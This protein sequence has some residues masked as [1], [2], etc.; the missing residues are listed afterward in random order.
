LAIA[1][2]SAPRALGQSEAPTVTVTPSFVSQYMWRGQRLGGLSLQTS[3]EADDRG[4]GLGVWAN[5]P[6]ADKV[7]NQS[8]PEVDPY[9][10]WRLPVADRV[11]VIPGFQIYTYPGADAEKV[12]AGYFRTRCELNAGLEFRCGGVTLMPKAAYDFQLRGGDLE[13]NGFYAVPLASIGS[14]LDFKAT[15]GAFDYE[16]A[17][18]G[19][20][21]S[22]GE[23]GGYALAGATLP[24]RISRSA[25]V[26][27]GWAYTEGFD[28]RFRVDGFPNDHNRLAGGRNVVSISF[29]WTF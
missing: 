11:A 14:E 1:A 25:K 2:V 23:S 10:Y 21:P 28:D 19:A 29:A 3:V 4:F 18:G 12:V 6:M 27:L 7:P 22:A 24:F 16:N 17:F 13:L 9:G 5:Q 8:S 26:S 20:T 15:A